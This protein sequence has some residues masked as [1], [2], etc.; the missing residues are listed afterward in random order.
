[1]ACL[2]S[3]VGCCHCLSCYAYVR[4][5]I[6]ALFWPYHENCVPMCI[7]FSRS[8]SA[9]AHRGLVFVVSLVTIVVA[10]GRRLF[11]TKTN[12]FLQ[13]ARQQVQMLIQK[14]LAAVVAVWNTLTSSARRLVMCA[15]RSAVSVGGAS[16][17]VSRRGACGIT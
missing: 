2:A 11:H 14:S 8:V 5:I 6:S 4:L 7:H 13:Q 15:I 12:T 1:M 17:V 10:A 9:L 16:W 3:V